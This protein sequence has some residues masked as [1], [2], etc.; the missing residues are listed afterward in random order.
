MKFLDRHIQ[1]L[2]AGV[3]LGGAVMPGILWSLEER[4]AINITGITSSTGLADYYPA[5]YRG[6]DEPITWFWLLLPYGLFIVLRAWL[7]PST[8]TRKNTLN[9]AVSKGRIEEINTLIE[10][11]TDVN[12]SDQSGETPLHSASYA[13]K[14]EVVSMLLNRGADLDACDIETGVRPLHKAAQKG[15]VQ[16]CELLIRHGAAMDAQTREGATAL[17]LA[18]RAGHTDLV[19]VLLKYHANHTLQDEQEHTAMQCALQSGHMEIATRIEQHAQN[20]W[21]YLRRSCR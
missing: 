6:L 8:S 18:A 7:L 5:F 13:C 21:P 3:A 16:A 17:H 10:T 15:C 14:P 19:A 1:Y 9:R 2:L 12:A 20:E 4:F 11:G